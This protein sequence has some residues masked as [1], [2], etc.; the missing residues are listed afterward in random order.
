MPSLKIGQTMA[1]LVLGISSIL[2]IF[3]ISSEKSIFKHDWSKNP[4]L[5]YAAFTTISILIILVLL[6]QLGSFIL[7]SAKISVLHWLFVLILS[8]IP[9]SISEFFKLGY[10]NTK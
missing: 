10:V 9:V 4:K 7:N 8:L 5:V 6:P 3:N 1:F 2:N